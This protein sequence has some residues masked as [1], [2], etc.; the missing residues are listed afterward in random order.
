[1]KVGTY[2]LLVNILSGDGICY[3]TSMSMAC[4]LELDTVE[5]FETG[6]LTLYR[7]DPCKELRNQSQ[8]LLLPWY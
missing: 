5:V 2:I 4:D 7:D 6:S 3:D 1:M 8:K